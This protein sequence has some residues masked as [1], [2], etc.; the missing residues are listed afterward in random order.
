MSNIEV[1]MQRRL[2]KFEEKVE[3]LIGG[4]LPQDSKLCFMDDG[5]IGLSYT[6]S[7]AIKELIKPYGT[8]LTQKQFREQCTGNVF[9]VD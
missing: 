7:Y 6:S 8:D 4:K 5:N 9:E 2:K 1:E 3:E